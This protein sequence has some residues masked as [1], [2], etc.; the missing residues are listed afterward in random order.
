MILNG[1][2]SLSTGP[3]QML[4]AFLAGKRLH[5]RWSRIIC[6]DAYCKLDLAAHRQGTEPARHP[7]Y[8]GRYEI[9]VKK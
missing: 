5:R 8:V 2:S 6:P 3:G 7:Y 9:V 4:G 1:L